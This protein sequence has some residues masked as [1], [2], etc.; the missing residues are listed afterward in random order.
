MKRLSSLAVWLFVLVAGTMA[1]E[2]TF[3]IRIRY[4]SKEPV[5][6][7]D[8]TVI[9]KDGEAPFVFSLMTNDPVNGKVLQQSAP[10]N[11][12]SYTFSGVLPGKYFLRIEDSRKF[13]AGETIT[14]SASENDR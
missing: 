5:R 10:V 11:G 4:D 9:V 12:K 14:I 1:Q 3:D 7:A 8:V 2:I 13:P 6:T